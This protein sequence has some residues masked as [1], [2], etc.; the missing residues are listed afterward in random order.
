[1]SLEAIA[2]RLLLRP[3]TGAP[4]RCDRPAVGAALLARL[5][6]GRRAGLVPDLLAAV[7]SLCAEAQR[8]TSRRALRAALGEPLSA[9][10]Q[11]HEARWL[12]LQVARE[13][14]RRFALDLPAATGH[15]TEGM[16]W[17]R[18]ASAI[19]A[20]VPRGGDA[21][22]LADAEAALRAW[23]GQRLLGQAPEAVW[24]AWQAEGTAWLD[25]WCRGHDH[26]VARWFANVRGPAQALA[27]PCRP[28]DVLDRGEAGLRTLAADIAADPGFAER[29][30]WGGS[31]AETGPWTRAGSPGT[32]AS[33]W[34]RLGARLGELARLGSGRP[35]AVGALTTGE[36]EGIAWTEMSRGLLVHAVRLEPGARDLHGARVTRCRVL[37]PTEWNFHPE[38]GFAA[39]LRG[40]GLSPAE[41]RLAVAALDPCVGVTLEEPADHA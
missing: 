7:F 32:V 34:Q 23:L 28:L 40:G 29:P 18:A 27:W 15:V 33:C 2:G 21:T 20:P 6:E 41:I 35:L 3:G 31:P 8:A 10:E 26:P 5:T 25:R 16:H 19:T 4:V 36:G 11:A 13:H 24:E 17:L 38:G 37:A 14:L 9:T 12:G 30:R 22:V 39:L 1:M